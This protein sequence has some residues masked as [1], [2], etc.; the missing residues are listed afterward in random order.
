M[1]NW[2]RKPE[3]GPSE[4]NP[5]SFEK[6]RFWLWRNLPNRFRGEASISSGQAEKADKLQFGGGK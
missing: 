1:S 5:M 2:Q 6:W 4:Q 3:P